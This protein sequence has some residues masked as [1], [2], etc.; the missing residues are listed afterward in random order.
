VPDDE[1]SVYFQT[2]LSVP[3]T[4]QYHL[5]TAS[6]DGVILLLD[7]KTLIYDWNQHSLTENTSPLLSLE[8]GKR[9]QLELLYFEGIV[10]AVVRLL[11][12][13]VGEDRIIIPAEYFTL[14][15]A[16]FPSRDLSR[17]NFT[18]TDSEGNLIIYDDAL[19]PNWHD[20]SWANPRD[21]AYSDNTYSGNHAIAIELDGWS[22]LSPFFSNGQDWSKPGYRGLHTREFD[23]LSFWVH[24]G[25]TNGGQTIGVQ[26]SDIVRGWDWRHRAHF[27]VPEDDEWHQIVIPLS[28]L[29]GIDM[30][31]SRL[32]MI[33]NGQDTETILFDEIRLLKAANPVQLEYDAMP[34][35]A[36]TYWLF[37]DHRNAILNSSNNAEIIY[38][39]PE[40]THGVFGLAARFRWYG[41]LQFRP[42]DFKW[43]NPPPF[44]LQNA[45]TLS[46]HIK[47]GTDN[48]PDQRYEAYVIDVNGDVSIKL[49]LASYLSEA[50]EQGWQIAKIPLQHFQLQTE[51]PIY[52]VGI[53]EMNG[54][55]GWTGFIYLDEVRF[56]YQ[57][58]A[59]ALTVYGDTLAQGWENWSWNSSVNFEQTPTKELEQNNLL[60][61]CHPDNRRDLKVSKDPSYCRDDKQGNY[62]VPS[63]KAIAV[64]YNQAWAGLYLHTDTAVNLY[65]YNTLRFWIHGGSSGGQQLRVYLVDTNDQL[66]EANAVAVTTQANQWTQIEIRL[67]EL[68][69]PMMI[70]GIVWQDTSG[71]AQPIFYID[72]IELLYSDTLP[73]PVAGPNLQVDVSAERHPISADIYGINFA[74]E[75]LATEL[76]LPVRRWGGNATT[77]YNWQNDTT[78]RASDWFFEN[79]PNQNDHPENLPNGSDS[80]E[81]V[82]QDQRTGTKSLLTLPLIGWSAKE[83]AYACGFS[84]TK[85]GAQQQTD[86]WRSDCGNGLQ[87]DGT[88][89]TGN[90]PTD[91][92]EAITPQFVQ[93]WIQHLQGRYGS[94]ILYNLDNEPMLWNHT[95]RDVHPNPVSYDELR[96]RTYQ[97]AAAVKATDSAAKTLGPAVWGWTAYFYSALDQAPGGNWWEN[98]L[99]RKAHGDMPLIAW[100]LQQMQIYEQQH[101]YRIL[102]YLDLHFYPQANGVALNSA[103]DSATQA[104]RLRST[105]ALWDKTYLDES[106]INEPVYLI[107]RMREWVDTYYPGTQLAVTEYN[108]GG[109]EHINGALAQ[110]EVLGIFGREGL[111]LAT[112]WAP[113][114]PQQPGAFAFRMYRN[115]DGNG[116]GF[117]DVSISASSDDPDKLAIYAAER[118]T[119]GAL[120]VML[121]N[122]TQ[123]SLESN[124]D[125]AGFNAMGTVQVFRYSNINLN[126]IVREADLTLVENTLQII[127]APYSISLLVI[128]AVSQTAFSCKQVTEIPKKECQ[129][130]IALYNST[131]GENWIDNTGWNVTNTPCS[132][133]G[134]TCQGGHVT[135][136]SLGDNNLKGSISAKLFKLK[137]LESLVLSDNDLNGTSLKKFNKLNKLETLSLNNCKLSGKLPNSLMKLNKLYELDLNDN[138]FLTKV[139]KKLKAWLDGLNPGWDETQTACFE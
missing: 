105:R 51:K 101:G 11:I 120:T 94:E 118:S 55:N 1:F 22:A 119:D 54:V 93:D 62:F 40:K 46:F 38:Q 77:R 9:Y 87:P 70:K 26:L 49:P 133:Y 80:D 82:E 81:F 95:H 125:L 112:L 57:P 52:A 29:D 114:E 30:Q 97:Y 116:N 19:A 92:S 58:P 48:A 107:P 60:I 10:D 47:F 34:Q 134:V 88:P 23:N 69:A 129:A 66:L 131:D 72:N 137:K 115:Y 13:P 64:T 56:E 35:S 16:D 98:P 79:I 37:R 124:L 111:D 135:S 12:E 122:K 106:W 17:F 25:Q 83:R 42:L 138:C 24:R 74:S 5:I 139:S 90:D 6:D 4:G 75:E 50:P 32:A 123:Q 109:L 127:S 67:S 68:A 84:V 71:G 91:T 44:V 31:L 99:D 100:Y 36:D 8:A 89:I 65:D 78:N 117:G 104:L 2:Y 96:D 7:G 73:P 15:D 61:D 86:P 128:P 14:P 76:R 102:D 33:G 130:L 45:N 20:W 63:P 121:I 136:L 27:T 103:G 18:R 108:W 39:S 132:W 59:E 85:Y 110:A 113:P 53:Q 43:D 41:Y 28:D 3:T 21:F 126:T